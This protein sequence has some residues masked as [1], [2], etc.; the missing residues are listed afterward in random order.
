MQNAVPDVLCVAQVNLEGGISK[1]T[2]ASMLGHGVSPNGDL[3][4]WTVGQQFQ[5]N[6]F[7]S[8]SGNAL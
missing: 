3:I 4:P 5:D 7:P 1:R 2:V 8:L 6:G